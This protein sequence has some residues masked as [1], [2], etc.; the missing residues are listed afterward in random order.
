MLNV[1]VQHLSTKSFEYL[2]NQSVTSD[3]IDNCTNP[4][5]KPILLHV[6]DS[7]KL[8]CCTTGAAL[9]GSNRLA[10]RRQQSIGMLHEHV[11][12]LPAF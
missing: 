1:Q 8:Q 9:H 2:L 4:G 12:A 7:A 5:R 11:T 6:H 3:L 10:V